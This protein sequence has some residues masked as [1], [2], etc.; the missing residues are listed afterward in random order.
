MLGP[1]LAPAAAETEVLGQPSALQLRAEHA[2]IREVLAALAASFKLTYRLPTNVNRNLNVRYSGNLRGVLA[3]IL[4]GND[5]FVKYVDDG[6]EVIVL[7]ASEA[8]VASDTP[9]KG[10]GSNAVPPKQT[11]AAPVPP[12]AAYLTD[13]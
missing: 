5:Y 13:K 11:A 4:D 1:D 6:I 10:G 7:R 8:V 3:R 12:L 9:P 2:S